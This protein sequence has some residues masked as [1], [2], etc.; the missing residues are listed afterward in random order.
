MSHQ[1]YQNAQRITEDPRATEYRLFGQVTGALIDAQKN[2]ITGRAAGRGD[3]LE[4]AAVGHA[5]GRLHGRPQSPCPRK[6][7]RKIVSLS[8]WVT[9]YS[10]D[11]MRQGAAWIR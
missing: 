8:L 6:C 3:R 11:V 7:A 2:G 5:C 4:P 10:Q 1:A 9:Q